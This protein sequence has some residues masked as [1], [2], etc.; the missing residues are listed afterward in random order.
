MLSAIDLLPFPLITDPERRLEK[1]TI[2]YIQWRFQGGHNTA[3]IG[4][5]HIRPFDATR[6]I[7]IIF[8]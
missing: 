7:I 2:Q 8:R 6:Y 1:M 5:A 3:T 4:S